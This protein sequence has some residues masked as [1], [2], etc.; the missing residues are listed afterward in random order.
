[1]RET[2]DCD[3]PVREAIARVDQWV[4]PFGFCSNVS[5]SSS[6]TCSSETVRGRPVRGSSESPSSRLARNCLRQEATVCRV[7]PSDSATGLVE[8]G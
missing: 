7:T 1:M 8:T 5:A 4:A 6:A 2:V 3:T